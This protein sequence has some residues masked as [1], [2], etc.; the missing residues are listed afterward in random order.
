MVKSPFS[1]LYQLHLDVERIAHELRERRQ[2]GWQPLKTHVK[3]LYTISSKLKVLDK[4]PRA[5]FDESENQD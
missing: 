5:R 2:R 1:P 4:N 3:E